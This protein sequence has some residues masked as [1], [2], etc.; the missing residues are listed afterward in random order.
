MGAYGLQTH[1][2]NNNWK[3][4]LLM[5][6][7]PVLLL[8]LT[9]A[10]FLLFAGLTGTYYGNDPMTGYFMWAG[11]ALAQAWPYAI[12]G[13]ILWFGIAYAFYQNI[14]DAATGARKVERIAEPKLYNL[15][16]NLCI[17]RGL[18]MP[19]LRIMETDALNAFATGLHKGNYCITVTRGLMNTLNDEELE[20]VLAHELT[21][22]RNADVRLL[23]IA[24]IFVGIFSFVGEITFRSLRWGVPSGGG[25]SRRS[26]GSSRDSGGGAI[27]AIVVAL[28]IIAIAYA[29]AIVIRFAL[30]RRREYLADAGAVELTKNP[31]AMITA[32]Q[33]I[34][35]NSVVESA[36][37]EVREMFIENPH[38]DFASLFATHPPIAKRIEALSKFAGGRVPAPQAQ[39]PQAPSPR[40]PSKRGP[41]G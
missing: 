31:D 40:D 4:V 33:K 3:T 9:Y 12:A 17:S 21:H 26:S 32:L 16:E 10:L 5:A 36:P 37:S 35:G 27:I 28:A 30:S 2:W 38:S 34:S 8:L 25:S 11:D 29:L 41:W 24:V 15:L 13:A 14:I 7:F 22:I 39:I 1:I 20:A 23:I 6:G 18:T 19:A